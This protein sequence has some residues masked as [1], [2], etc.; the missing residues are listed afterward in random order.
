MRA[1]KYK[2]CS[3]SLNDLSSLSYVKFFKFVTVLLWHELEKQLPCQDFLPVSVKKSLNCKCE[4]TAHF[5]CAS[6]ACRRP[7]CTAYSLHLP[8]SVAR[9]NH[10][11][12][13]LT[14][15]KWVL[16]AKWLDSDFRSMKY[17]W[18]KM[19]RFHSRILFRILLCFP[20]IRICHK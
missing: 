10:H 16:P 3:G 4:R 13:L 9:R 11:Q 19:T 1:I 17:M 15:T 6:P 8:A 5:N 2:M 20:N 7:I 18:L 12:Y 14:D